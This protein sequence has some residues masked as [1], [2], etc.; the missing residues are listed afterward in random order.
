MLSLD[1]SNL[2]KISSNQTFEKLLKQIQ[3]RNQGFYKT[4]ND[5]KLIKEI[6]DFEKKIRNKY[7][8]IVVLGIGGSALGTAALSQSFKHLYEN[9]L[10][11]SKYPKLYILDNIDPTM[12]SELEDI[13]DYS[14]TLFIVATKSGSTAET[15]TQYFYFRERCK[16]LK[17]KIKDHFVLIT[18]EQKTFLR[19]TALKE[20]IKIF[21]IP[22]NICGRFSVFSNISLLPA[23]LIGIDISKLIKGA[24]KD[25]RNIAFQLAKIQYALSRKGKIINILMPYSQNLIGLTNWYRQLLAESI[26]KNLRTGITPVSALG[27]T[28]QHSQL[29]LYA[30]GPND[31]LIIFIETKKFKKEVIIPNP[32]PE[33]KGLNFLNKHLTFN[34]L[35][36]IE[37]N[38]TI[39]SLTKKHKPSIKISIDL[40]NEESIGELLMMFM[41]SVAFLGELFKINTFNQ[42]GVEMSKSLT[43]KAIIS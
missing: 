37:K 35:I 21:D 18:G 1:A 3:K 33:N 41:W 11:K 25:T 28:D 14:K 43:K 4:V 24:K 17:L 23:K 34:E 20:N 26:G 7:K 30:D 10:V 16:R 15:G 8:H 22:E 29:Q 5:K 32:Y 12:I 13:I 42:P 6:N 36:D 38:S 19:E 39:T 2:K 31:K 27:V 40:I 9:E